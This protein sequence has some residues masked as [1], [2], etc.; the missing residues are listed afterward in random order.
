[1]TILTCMLGAYWANVS[2]NDYLKYILNYSMQYIYILMSYF[3]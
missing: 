1:M 2:W 3:K